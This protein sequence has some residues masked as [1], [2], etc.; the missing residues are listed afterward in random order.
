MNWFTTNIGCDWGIMRGLKA[1]AMM[2][3]T[4]ALVASMAIARFG[5]VLTFSS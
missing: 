2:T 5:E 1:G 4:V 3:G